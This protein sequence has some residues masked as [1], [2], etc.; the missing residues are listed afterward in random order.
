MSVRSAQSVTVDFTTRVW[1]TGIGTNADSLPTGK[2]VLNGTDNAATVTVTSI[3]TGVYS[4]QVTLPTLAIGDVVSLRIAATV[5][6]ISDAAIIWT[7]T[8]DVLLDSSGNTTFNNTTLATVTTVTG[9]LTAAQIA[10][11]IFQDTTAG[12][13]T[14]ANSIGKSLYT[15]GVAP[16]GSGGLFIAGTNAA[17]TVTTSFTTTFTGNLAGS[18]ASVTGAVGSVTNAITL[19]SIPTGWI[20]TAGFASGATIPACTL[21]ATT[22]ALTNAP[23]SGDFTATMKTSIGTAVAASAVASVTAQVTANVTDINGVSCA[24][25]TTINA[26]LGSTQAITFDSNNYQKVDVVDIAGTASAGT[27][28]YVGIDWGNLH[29]AGSTVSLTGTT[30]ATVTAVGTLTTYTGNTVQ[31]G[32]SFARIG[33]TGSGLTSLLSVAGYTAPN[34]TDIAAIYAKLPT[35]AIADET[36]VLAAIT[37]IVTL[38]GTPANSTVSADIAAAVADILALPSA[39]GNATAVLGLTSGVTTGFSLARILRVIAAAIVGN[40]SGV[41]SGSPVYLDVGTGATAVSGTA[42]EGDRSSMEWEA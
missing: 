18:V 5:S 28:G 42:S 40:S 8:K 14:V 17:T 4:A 21:T 9:Q 32:D 25:V 3:S 31:T 24:S 27:A 19:P 1:S 10:T 12:D 38:L 23:T 22:T 26:N 41:S 11:G 36:L 34:N 29:G 2:L 15:S 35:N 37:A 30:I 33:A 20:T 16:G 7:D 39:A 6:S 13:F